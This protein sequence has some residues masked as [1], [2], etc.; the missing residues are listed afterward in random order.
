VTKIFELKLEKVAK[1]CGN[2]NSDDLHDILLVT[3]HC[4]E[5]QITKYERGRCVWHIG[6]GGMEMVT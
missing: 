4:S 2:F 5:D 1:T 6:G 3:K